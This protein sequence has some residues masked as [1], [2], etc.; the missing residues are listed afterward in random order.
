MPGHVRAA[1]VCDPFPESIASVI[2]L[3]RQASRFPVTEVRSDHHET[4][5]PVRPCSCLLKRRAGK[6]GFT[7][8]SRF[9]KFF[10]SAIG[11]VTLAA[12]DIGQVDTRDGQRLVGPTNLQ[13]VSITFRLWKTDCSRLQTFI[14]AS[15]PIAIPVE[16]LQPIGPLVGESEMASQQR[17][18]LQSLAERRR[19]APRGSYGSRTE[20]STQRFLTSRVRSTRSTSKKLESSAKCGRVKPVWNFQ[21]SI[22]QMNLQQTLS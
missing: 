21:K 14:P 1:C 2:R 22:D 13:P 19:T 17:I 15:Q 12:I 11:T 3:R 9:R 4:A 16:Q 8:T 20:R 6:K 5:I 18:F 10:S 7:Q